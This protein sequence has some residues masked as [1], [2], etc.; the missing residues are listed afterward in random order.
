[1][2]IRAIRNPAPKEFGEGYLNLS[3]RLKE[4]NYLVA[5]PVPVPVVPVAVVPLAGVVVFA[6]SSQPISAR[7]AATAQR[8]RIVRRVL[9]D[10]GCFLEWCE[11]SRTKTTTKLGDNNRGY[12]AVDSH[13]GGIREERNPS[14]YLLAM[15]LTCV[16]GVRQQF[17][18]V[19]WGTPNNDPNGHCT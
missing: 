14:R 5:A 19:S 9:V 13:A 17:L 6:L 8:P 2:S 15:Q 3:K 1:M 10:I 12:L 4:S 7:G 11:S 16:L 18:A